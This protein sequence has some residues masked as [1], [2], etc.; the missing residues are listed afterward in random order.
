MIIEIHIIL[1]YPWQMFFIYYFISKSIKKLS[2]GFLLY[3]FLK[4]IVPCFI[5]FI[6][7]NIYLVF[8]YIYQLYVSL[9]LIS[10]NNYPFFLSL[11]NTCTVFFIYLF[12]IN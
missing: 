8:L 10:E 11:T 3:F 4:Y 1:Y 2:C 7:D 12:E 6:S 5:I 9:I